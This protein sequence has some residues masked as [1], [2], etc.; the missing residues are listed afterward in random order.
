MRSKSSASTIT[1]SSATPAT[2]REATSNLMRV[3]D[4]EYG[5][6][7]AQLSVLE[8]HAKEKF[9]THQWSHEV[10][11]DWL[12]TADPLRERMFAIAMQLAD[13]PVQ[14][15]QDLRTMAKVLFD[16]S[17]GEDGDVV[18]RLATALCSGILKNSRS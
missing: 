11:V 17:N 18:H 15:D 9:A 6:L 5:A 1:P 10:E 13:M 16:F 7:L 14:S 12:A 4:Q 2:A 8:A 3:L